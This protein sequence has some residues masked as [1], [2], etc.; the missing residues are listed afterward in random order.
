M[1]Q[2][3]EEDKLPKMVCLVCTTKLDSMAQFALMAARSQTKLLERLSSQDQEDDN[4]EEP[5]GGVLKEEERMELWNSQVESLE[6]QNESGD[7]EEDLQGS[8]LHSILTKVNIS[9]SFKPI[10]SLFNFDSCTHLLIFTSSYVLQS[11]I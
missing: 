1:F 3:S 4:D 6:D 7:L 8:L 9:E 11:H 10:N 2:I 5:D